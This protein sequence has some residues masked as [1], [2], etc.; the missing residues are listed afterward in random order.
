[1][2]FLNFYLLQL[3]RALCFVFVVLMIAADADSHT[4]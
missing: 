1:M 4:E 2:Q 3:S